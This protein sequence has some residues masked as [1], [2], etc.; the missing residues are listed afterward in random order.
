MKVSANQMA[1][2]RC[3]AEENVR[4]M[5]PVPRDVIRK[6]AGVRERYLTNTIASCID[7]GWLVVAERGVAAY[8]I[9][10]AGLAVVQS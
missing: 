3:V 5:A 7:R 1:V 9:T 4:G 6:A 8:N 10:N 2:L